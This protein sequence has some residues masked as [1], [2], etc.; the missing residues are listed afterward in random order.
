MHNKLIEQDLDKLRDKI[1]IMGGATEQAIQNSIRA[2]IE[3]DSGLAEKV[4]N[5]DDEIDRIEL[6]IDRICV[7][8]LV[9]KQPAAS[10]LRYV[11]SIARTSPAIERM[12]DH[13][14][15]IAK[16]ALELNREPALDLEIDLTQMGRLVQ[17]MLL[18]GLDSFTTGDTEKARLTI[19]KD[20]DVDSYYDIFSAKVI[21]M[22]TRDS[23]TV[24]RGVQLLFVL[25]HL[26]RIADYV[27]NICEQLVY[28]TRG[29][30][31][32]HTIW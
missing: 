15:N 6:E 8:I 2:L 11:V 17:E 18:E 26:E 27:T 20:D 21:E 23:S 22:M 31:I 25:K 19:E 14:V 12:A 13:A 1:L 7:D 10:D 29:E 28:V 16:H 32:K 3:R 9:L 5:D 4:I 30:V 24:S